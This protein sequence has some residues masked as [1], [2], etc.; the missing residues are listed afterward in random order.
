[1][2]TIFQEADER[3]ATSKWPSWECTEDSRLWCVVWVGNHLGNNETTWMNMKDMMLREEARHKGT[4]IV[5]FHSHEVCIIVKCIET[6]S[7]IAVVSGWGRGM[8]GQ[9]LT[10]TRVSVRGDEKVLKIDNGDGCI[11]WDSNATELF[12]H[13]GLERSILHIY[14]LPQLNKIA[15]GPL[16]VLKA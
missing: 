12:T 1:M 11:T 13:K 16:P 8:G 4:N 2:T 3:K 10:G 7:R 14:C 6:E 9:C 5:W 15:M